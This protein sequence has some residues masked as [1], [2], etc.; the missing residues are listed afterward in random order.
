VD[1]GGGQVEVLD[2]GAVLAVQAVGQAQL[3]VGLRQQPAV[4]LQVSLLQRQALPEVLQGLAVVPWRGQEG[5]PSS[6]V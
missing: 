1:D 3:V 5:K 6:G 2:G 4:R